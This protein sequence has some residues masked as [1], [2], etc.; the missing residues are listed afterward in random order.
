MKRES[1]DM[2]GVVCRTWSLGLAGSRCLRWIGRG[3]TTDW[4]SFLEDMRINCN[5]RAWL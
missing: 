5:T 2:N 3:F 1:R 4:R